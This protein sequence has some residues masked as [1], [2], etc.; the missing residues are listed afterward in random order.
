MPMPVRILTLVSVLFSLFAFAPAAS[1]QSPGTV[2][3]EWLGWNA[4]RLTSPGGKVVLLNPFIANPDSPI[5]LEQI[6]RADIILVTNGH[7]DEV[8]QTVDIAKNTGARIIPGS[9][10]LGAWFRTHDLPAAQAMT[11][12]PGDAITIDGIRIRVVHSVHGSAINALGA[13]N[14]SGG[15]AGAFFITFENGWTVYYGGSGSATGD[16]ALWAELYQP[17]A[18]ILHM[19]A[20]HEPWDVAAMVR[21]LKS[22]NPN[23]SAIF[24]GHHRSADSHFPTVQAALDAWNLGLQI[25]VPT[26]GL[27]MDFTM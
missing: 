9:F 5:R 20:S 3:M 18:A 24:P 11:M 16:Q 19:S 26:P 22:G 12:S 14:I 2:T 6:D 27:S 25:T 23:L 10:E 1:A 15:V 17:H 7:G 4:W 8:G 13:G 21:Y